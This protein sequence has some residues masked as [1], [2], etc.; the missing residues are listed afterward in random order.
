MKGMKKV[1]IITAIAAYIS[2]KSEKKP[3]RRRAYSGWRLASRLDLVVADESEEV[4]SAAGWGG[5][6]GRGRA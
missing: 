1:A 2:S 5:L 4:Q 3:P 6:R